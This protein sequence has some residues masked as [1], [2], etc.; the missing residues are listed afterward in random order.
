[1]F[2]FPGENQRQPESQPGPY[3]SST[4][5]EPDTTESESE[6]EGPF[7][8]CV[9]KALP[10]PHASREQLWRAPASDPLLEP[11]PEVQGPEG[12]LTR[13]LG[14]IGQL[15]R[16]AV[17]PTATDAVGSRRR[18]APVTIHDEAARA[19]IAVL[20]GELGLLEQLGALHRHASHRARHSHTAVPVAS[21]LPVGRP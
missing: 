11:E 19:E 3:T 18:M 17:H 9:R 4:E 2:S 6:T 20:A 8:G 13:V 21:H 15:A 5:S 1:M 14:E 16:H 7:A 10:S 12:E